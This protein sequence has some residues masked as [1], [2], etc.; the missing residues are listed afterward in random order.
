M[1][2]EFDYTIPDTAS[3][4]ECL[5]GIASFL[6][7]ASMNAADNGMEIVISPVAA[8]MMADA[9]MAVVGPL[10]YDEMERQNVAGHA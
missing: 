5:L 10:A 9:I 8:E 7:D 4:I 6:L 2:R 3:S 1:S